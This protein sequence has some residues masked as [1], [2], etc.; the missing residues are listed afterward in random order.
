MELLQRAQSLLQECNDI[1]AS[2]DQWKQQNPTLDV[3]GLQAMTSVLLAEQKFLT[4][5][6]E[7]THDH[8][9]C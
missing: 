9:R 7:E 2:L 8:A 1:A 5:V 3:D 4:K 6:Q